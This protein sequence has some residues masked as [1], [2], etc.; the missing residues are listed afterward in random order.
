MT[1]MKKFLTALAVAI[2]MVGIGTAPALAENH[3][4]G[5]LPS[6]PSGD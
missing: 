5:P 1:P 4:P 3:V 2:A 6:H